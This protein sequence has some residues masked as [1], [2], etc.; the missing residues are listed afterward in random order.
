LGRG[1]CAARTTTFRLLLL[2]LQTAL[3]HGSGNYGCLVDG[4][5]AGRIPVPVLFG[6]TQ[7]LADSH[8]MIS[9]VSRLIYHELREIMYGGLVNVVCQGDDPRTLGVLARKS[10]R[11]ILLGLMDVDCPVSG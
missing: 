2:L 1:R 9:L 6:V 5:P 3:S 7:A 4:T 8:E 11:E 10:V